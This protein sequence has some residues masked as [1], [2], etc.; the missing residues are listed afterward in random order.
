MKIELENIQAKMKVELENIQ[1]KMKIELENIQA[2]IFS[3]WIL[4]EITKKDKF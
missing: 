3:K 4:G 2:K 1:A